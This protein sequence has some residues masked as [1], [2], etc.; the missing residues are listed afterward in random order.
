MIDDILDVMEL[1]VDYLYRLS[2]KL[3]DLA[4]NLFYGLAFILILAT[5]PVWILPF[6]I[7][8][9]YKE[10]DRDEDYEDDG[11][12]FDPYTSATR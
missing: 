7:W 6:L 1:I 11:D 9:S 8:K 10:K 5:L 2:D 12:K 3:L 4:I